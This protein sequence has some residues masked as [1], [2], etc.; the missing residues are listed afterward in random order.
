[1]R[2]VSRSSPFGFSSEHVL[3][4][5]SNAFGFSF[6]RVSYNNRTCP[7][8]VANAFIRGA[9]ALGQKCVI[10]CLTGA[11][12]DV[13][14]SMNFIISSFHRLSTLLFFVQNSPSFFALR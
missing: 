12:Y 5:R 4:F 14:T 1:M 11:V 2:L 9:N 10:P 3:A 6:E 7:G 13:P 8:S